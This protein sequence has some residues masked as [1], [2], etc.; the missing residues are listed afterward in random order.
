MSA[1]VYR[2]GGAPL[3]VKVK[4]KPWQSQERFHASEGT[5]R[6][7]AGGVGAGK[8]EAGAV[9][10]IA[11]AI[12]NPGCDGYI[13]A[14]T[15]GTLKRV[16]L[17]KFLQF[18]P[19]E[20]VREHNKGERYIELKNHSRVYYGSADNPSS[21]EGATIAWF[22]LDEARYCKREA[23]DV[24]LARLREPNA[25]RLCGVL[26]STPALGWLY[27]EFKTGKPDRSLVKLPT[28]A[29]LALPSSYMRTLRASYSKAL[30][31][32]YVL[33]EFVA[34]EGAVYGDAFNEDDHV[35]DCPHISG[36]P[37]DCF[38]DFGRRRPAVL[39][40]QRVND[41]RLHVIG[42]THPS[43]IPTADLSQAVIRLF[44]KRGW[45]RGTV[46]CD[47]AGNAKNTARGEADIEILE[48]DGW[49]VETPEGGE[50]K[51]IPYGVDMVR[52]K[53]LS[54][55]GHISIYFDRGLYSPEKRGVYQA[56]QMYS[57]P[58]VKDGRPVLDEPKKD[59][60]TDHAMD[61]LRYGCLCY[62]PPAHNTIRG[63]W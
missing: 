21:L 59:G 44:A 15:Y 55:D 2:P 54:V 47:P 43:M 14:P 12:E 3:N 46:Y 62:W 36:I 57:Y 25:K 9:E 60:V 6:L 52:E 30:F 34:L 35:I 50:S 23:Y 28:M 38:W 61:A 48:E 16:T 20:V 29:N 17:R 42:E 37:V 19:K 5:I 26:T 41:D 56:I 53:L 8:T 51:S 45:R 31:K 58:E 4:Y 40:V 1:P 22:W 27:D 32:Q 33:G 13:V 24:L 11:L 10:A 7:A 18:L 49:N 63:L 39:F